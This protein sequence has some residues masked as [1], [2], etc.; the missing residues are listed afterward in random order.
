MKKKLGFISLIVAALLAMGMTA[1]SHKY[2]D[3]EE[4]AEWVIHKAK[5]KLNLTESQ[6]AKL[7]DLKTTLMEIHKQKKAK[8]P[9]MRQQFMAMLD[10]PT[11]DQQVLLS[12]FDEKVAEIRSH[13]PVVVAKLAAFYDSLDDEQ[14]AKLK[15]LAEKHHK[16]H[17]HFS[18]G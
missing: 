11:L 3:P 2:D 13:L 6:E 4:R 5:N 16:R 7:V 10:Q 8:H 15:K 1:C 17:G 18:H 9:E 12:K 14:R